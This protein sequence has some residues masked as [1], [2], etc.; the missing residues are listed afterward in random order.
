MLTTVCWDGFHT[1]VKKKKKLERKGRKLK[2]KGKSSYADGHE[3]ATWGKNWRAQMRKW[4]KKEEKA[5]KKCPLWGSNS[6]PSDY[7]T[8]ALPTALRRPTWL[9]L[10]LVSLNLKQITILCARPRGVAFEV[11][12]LKKKVIF[13]KEYQIVST[14]TKVLLGRW[15]ER[16]RESHG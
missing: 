5:K 7:E 8:D 15:I 2:E 4:K 10:D 3:G 1:G 14:N 13:Y 12:N 11:L 16:N 9:G 6:R